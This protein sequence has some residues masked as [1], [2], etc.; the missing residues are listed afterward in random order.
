M[1]DYYDYGMPP[2]YWWAM[3]YGYFFVF[4]IYGGLFFYLFPLLQSAVQYQNKKWLGNTL[5]RVKG[6]DQATKDM[7]LS[8]AQPEFKEPLYKLTKFQYLAMGIITA[9]TGLLVA[10]IQDPDESTI[11]VLIWLPLVIGAVINALYFKSFPTIGL[12]RETAGFFGVL[13]LCITIPGIFAVYE[14][15]WMRS[16]LLVYL[17][18]TLSLVLVH[19]LES[20]IASLMYI[21]A[22]AIGSTILTANVGDNWMY[23]FKSFIWFFALAPLVFWMP[24]LK[25]AK[26]M[27]VKEIAFGILFMMM[28]LVVTGS[29]LKHLAFL[30]FA[31]MIP[32]LYMFSK[33]HFKQDGWF[34]TKPIQS[35]IVLL[36]FYGIVMMNFEDAYRVF[37]SF[38]RQFIDHFSFSWLVDLLIVIAMIFGAVMMYRD[39]YEEHPDRINLVVLAFPPAAY[40]L[41]FAADYYVNYLFIIVLLA[42]GYSYLKGG[43]DNKNPFAIM[44]GGMGVLTVIPVI[45][46]KLPR[47]MWQEQGVVGVLI[48]VY[49]IAMIGLAMYMR[50]QW[51][52][53]EHTDDTPKPLPNSADVLD[54]TTE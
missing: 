17:V 18:L 46:E 49:G 33:I 31:V 16:D 54:S 39:N 27:G 38:S 5:G 19:L 22:V 1:Y 51:T 32:T 44:L 10:V 15:D 29:N 45:Y 24:R 26:E 21:V 6:L 41:S 35:L 12:W 14:W 8:E 23:F 25:S 11:K 4:L 40:L 53:S 43:L 28:M 30:G 52:V 48:A 42:Y 7:I 2:Y 50:S 37:P 47:D 3:S 13:G 9:I 36:T 20:T 34:L